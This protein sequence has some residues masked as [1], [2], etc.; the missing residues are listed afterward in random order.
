MQSVLRVLLFLLLTLPVFAQGAR[1]SDLALVST[2]NTNNLDGFWIEVTTTTTPQTFS[3]GSSGCTKG[4]NVDWGDSSA[5]RYTHS[6][7]TTCSHSYAAPGVYQLKMS[8]NATRIVFYGYTPTLVTEILSAVNGINGITSCEAMFRG[9]TALAGTIPATMFDRLPLIAASGFNATFRGCT[10]LTGSIPANFGRYNTALSTSGFYYTFYGCTGL[11]GSIPTD[12]GRYNT[13]LSSSGYEATFSGCTGLTGSIPTDFGRYNTN[14]STYG[15]YSTFYGCTGLTGSI[16]TDFGRYN[17]GLSSNGY[18]ATFYGCNKLTGSIPTDFGRYNTGLIYGG[19][20]TT[21]YGCTG[22]TGSIP[23]DFG[24]YN[25]L[26]ST[27]GFQLTFYNCN[28]LTGAPA[29][30]FDYTPLNT[31]LNGTLR[32]CTLMV[33]AIPALT[34]QTN[35]TTVDFRSSGFTG[36]TTSTIPAGMKTVTLSGLALTVGAVNQCLVDFDAAGSSNGTLVLNGGTSA[37]PTVGPPDGVTAKANL[38]ARGWTVT[39]N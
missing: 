21:F 27:D 17:T 9:C 4:F 10:S 2:V 26:L 35:V 38:I 36:W 1:H 30:L 32:G 12:F 34:V 31:S 14:L 7:L 24:R 28:K 15:Y 22:L 13:S 5:T 37:A 18:G 11:T 20:Y 39:T 3:F 29:T 19:Y 33:G 23:T 16:P 6:A 8:G 25:T